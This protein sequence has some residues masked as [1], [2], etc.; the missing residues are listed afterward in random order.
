MRFRVEGNFNS[1]ASLIEG[2]GWGT[3][4]GGG[5]GIKPQRKDN[6]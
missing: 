2:G 5:L 4:T 3:G 1:P 6:P